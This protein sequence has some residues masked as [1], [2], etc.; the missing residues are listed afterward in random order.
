MIIVQPGDVLL[1]PVDEG[2]NLADGQRAIAQ[3]EDDMPGVAVTF[4]VG[5]RTTVVY[6]PATLAATDKAVEAAA[7]RAYRAEW[8]RYTGQPPWGDL[9]DDSREDWRRIARAVL[10]G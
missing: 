6:R 4:V 8:P 5:G 9:G 2:G 7:E 3:M 1:Y 10:G